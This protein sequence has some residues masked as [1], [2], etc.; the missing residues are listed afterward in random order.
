MYAA[1]FTALLCTVTPANWDTA[2]VFIGTPSQL[3]ER[4]Q[5]RPRRFCHSGT[6]PQAVRLAADHYPIVASG[7]L[8]IKAK[9][10]SGGWEMIPPKKTKT[11]TN[12]DKCSYLIL[13]LFTPGQEVRLHSLKLYLNCIPFCLQ[14]IALFRKLCLQFLQQTKARLL[15]SNLGPHPVLHL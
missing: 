1:V 6:I 13:S 12:L 14:L 7:I 3:S 15:V 2:F 9:G 11:T 8:S 4:R 5:W 10:E